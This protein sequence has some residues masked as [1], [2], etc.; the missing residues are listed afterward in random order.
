MM[1]GDPLSYMVD[2]ETWGEM[3]ETQK[4]AMR[5]ALGLN[6]SLFERF[7]NWLGGIFKG[8]FGYSLTSGVPIKKIISE[9]LPAT[10]ELSVVALLFSSIVGTF[11]GIISALR[12]GT[13]SD[14]VLTVAGLLGM[15][16]PQFFFGLVSLLLFAI[17]LG[18]FPIGGRMIAGK[19]TF[20]ERLPHLVLPSI[21]LGLFL[22]AGIMRYSRSSML[23]AA[24]KDFLRTARS[25]GIPEWKVNIKHG[26][27]VAMN[28]VIVLIGL[29]LP[30][31]IGGSVVIESV[32]QWPGIGKMFLTAV[33]GQNYPLVMSIALL[34]IMATMI[35]SFLID[36]LTA[37]M[38]PRVRL[39]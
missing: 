35:S 8:D 6:G 21:V 28:P 37:A 27:R 10:L 19:E 14:N 23:D 31:L 13:I 17:N 5:E 7:F 3:S 30:I 20:L 16:V 38:D 22:T 25:K 11:L 9:T 39:S 29:R 26:F 36:L 2:Q 24:N 33:R 34:M 18:W 12:K 32:F 4:D 1:P 15:S